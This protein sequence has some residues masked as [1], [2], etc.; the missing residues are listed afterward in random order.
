MEVQLES[1][2]KKLRCAACRKCEG[3][4]EMRDA[5]ARFTIGNDYL[6]LEG[7]F[8]KLYIRRAYVRI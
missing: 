3:D 5:L 2:I 7:V 6:G 4:E 1:F 8:K